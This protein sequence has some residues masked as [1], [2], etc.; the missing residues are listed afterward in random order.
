MAF[1]PLANMGALVPVVGWL[2]L[3]DEWAKRHRIFDGLPSGG[4]MD[5]TYYREI[6]PDLLFLGQDEPP[7]EVAQVAGQHE[8]TVPHPSVAL[9]AQGL[10]LALT[11]GCRDPSCDAPWNTSM[12]SF[13]PSP[14]G[15]PRATWAMRHC[16]LDL[17]W[18]VYAV[19]CITP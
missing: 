11:I 14:P 19:R 16:L 13:S 9:Q 8:Q 6:L 15:T 10:L 4:L 12:G 2:Y 3:K 17:S 1:L 18:V 5:Y 7:Q